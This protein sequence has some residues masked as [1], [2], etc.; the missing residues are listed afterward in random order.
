MAFQRCLE[1]TA[2]AHVSIW[3]CIYFYESFW[4]SLM[5]ILMLPSALINVSHSNVTKMCVTSLFYL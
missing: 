4:D 1:G 5:Y 3:L 2:D